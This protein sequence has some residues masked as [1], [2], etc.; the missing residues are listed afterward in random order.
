MNYNESMS[1]Q[2]QKELLREKIDARMVY[3]DGTMTLGGLAAIVILAGYSPAIA[4]VG[5][6]TLAGYAGARAYHVF[7]GKPIE[8]VFQK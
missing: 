7:T 6:V 5:F 3:V 2:T 1:A 4:A 8:K